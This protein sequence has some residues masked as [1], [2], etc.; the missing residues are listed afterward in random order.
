MKKII[1]IVVFAMFVIAAITS[2]VS[3]SY[4]SHKEIDKIILKKSQEQASLLA[5]NVEY[6]LE[7]SSQPI[8]D[9]QALVTA[10]K[11]R[12][13][14]SYAIV[15]NKDVKAVAHSDKEKINKVYD[16]SYSVAGAS[17][18]VSQHSKWYADVQEV[19]VYDIM[20]PV[21]VNGE[22]YGTVD[23][24]IPITEVS[25]AASDILMTQLVAISG[26]F[27]L[28]I[29]VLIWLM[30][31]LFKPLSGLQLA[32]EDIS[33]GDGDL[34]VR[35]PVKGDDEIANISKAFNAFAG[36]INEIITQVVKTGLDLGHSATDVRDQALR[37]LSRGEMQSEQ[38][39][40]VVTSMNEMIATINEISSNAS[41]AA[42]AAK[43]VNHET[44][45]GNNVLQEAAGTIRN[46]SEEINSTSL[47]ITSLAERTQSIGSILEVIN[48]I[49]EQTNLLALN[50]A[51]EAAR[52][53]EAGRGFA[54]VAD[55]VRTLATKTAQSTGEIQ[56]MIDQLQ[57]EAKSAVDAM[58]CSKSLTVEGSKAT[59]EAQEALT[60][61]SNQVIAILDLNTQ[62]AT[63]T[64]E[65]SSVSNE[66]NI[67]MDT[68]NNSIVEGAAASKELEVTSRNLTELAYTLD[69]HVGSFKI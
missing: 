38:S 10:L 52:A 7:K 32:L 15:I 64:E 48:G 23:I 21:Y 31:R 49:S 27:L 68:V 19:W 62:V 39:L 53:G 2:I 24:G 55:E 1:L 43:N 51:I 67:N 8:I 57:R 14:I 9:L 60:R 61:I 65:Q 35:L 47:V 54:V 26:I 3:T 17:Q 63:A 41:G 58:G 37:S 5:T 40:L 33:K 20:S 44:Q 34:T 25:D 42:D 28:C 45:E 56:N 29:C 22:L 16:D 46:L 13:D 30:G 18:G 12:P 36:N 50:A 59:E 4:I 11:V 69:Q 6:V 66:I